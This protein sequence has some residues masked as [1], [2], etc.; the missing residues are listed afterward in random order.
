MIK[1]AFICVRDEK[2]TRSSKWNVRSGS[3]L[4]FNSGFVVRKF[5]SAAHTIWVEGVAVENKTQLAKCNN[6]I[7]TQRQAVCSLSWAAWDEL[8]APFTDWVHSPARDEG[9]TAEGAVSRVT[10][11]APCMH[12]HTNNIIRSWFAHLLLWEIDSICIEIHES[13]LSHIF[14]IRIICN[15]DAFI[16]HLSSHSYIY[17]PSHLLGIFVANKGLKN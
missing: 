10:H 17:F 4:T 6:S 11:F 8:S 14:L 5:L 9:Q 12:A 13:R 7:S 1:I 3:S 15:L 16:S 2:E